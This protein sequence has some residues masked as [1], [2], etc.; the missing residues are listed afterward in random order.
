MQSGKIKFWSLFCV[1]SL[2]HLPEEIEVSPWHYISF[3]A[4]WENPSR[5]RKIWLQNIYFIYFWRKNSR[6]FVCFVAIICPI[7]EALTIKLRKMLIRQ[8]VFDIRRTAKR[9]GNC[10]TP[11]IRPG[12]PILQIY[13]IYKDALT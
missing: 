10:S 1:Y 13:P 8:K 5:F 11:N 12:I 9:L 4:H 2:Y 6:L 7:F 3:S